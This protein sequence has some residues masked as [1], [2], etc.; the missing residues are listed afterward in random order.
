MRIVLTKAVEYPDFIL[1]PGVVLDLPKHEAQPLLRAEAATRLRVAARGAK[2][3]KRR[4]T[5]PEL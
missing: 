3:R 1:G 4:P 5:K 2:P